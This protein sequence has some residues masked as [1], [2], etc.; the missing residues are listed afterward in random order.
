MNLSRFDLN[1]LLVFDTVLARESVSRAARHLNLSQP[2]VGHALAKLRQHL[3]DPLFVRQGNRMVAT[4]AALALAGPVRDALRRI[5][6]ALAETGGFDPARSTREFRIGVR[7]TG[8][9]PR[10]ARLAQQ[11]IAAAPGVR[12]ASISFRRR[13]LVRILASGECDAV[14]D[15]DLPHDERLCRQPLATEPLAVVARTGHPAIGQGLTLATYLAAGHIVASPRPS[16][17]GAEDI[18]L[19]QTGLQ[20]RVVVRCQHALTACRI[21]GES[22]LLCT[23]PRRHAEAIGPIWGLAL[24]DLPFTVPT[25]PANLYWHRE[26]HD[27]PANRW[28]R[29]LILDEGVIPDANSGYSIGSFSGMT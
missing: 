26:A 10:F 12:L 14:I 13:D 15:I 16:G 22:D 2:A 1:L 19:G 21:V 27:D 11:V 3:G 25:P 5:E 28:L 7:P 24:H 23:L 8:E 20:R 17:P 29:G 4:P 9:L 6:T 18:A